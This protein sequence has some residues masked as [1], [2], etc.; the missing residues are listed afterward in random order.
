MVKM[1]A[2][3]NFFSRGNYY[4]DVV[5]FEWI[6]LTGLLFLFKLLRSEFHTKKNALIVVMFFVPSI[7]F[8]LSGIR[9]EGLLVF[10]LGVLLYYTHCWFEKRRIRYFLFII[11]AFAGL[12]IFRT[13]SL[14][15][16][17]PAFF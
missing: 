3:F 5:F 12:F 17:L 11:I 13:S 9:A 4:I 1:L 7:A 6:P 8:W 10:F 15:I 16:L 14:L 2:V